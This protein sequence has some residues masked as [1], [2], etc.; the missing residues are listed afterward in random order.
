MS[1]H[2]LRGRNWWGV[3]VDGDH[4]NSTEDRGMLREAF[5]LSYVKT[6]WF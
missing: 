1:L 6:V 3:M 4:I 2:V 5:V